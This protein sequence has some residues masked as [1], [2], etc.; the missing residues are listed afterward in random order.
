MNA[1]NLGSRKIMDDILFK[2]FY[3]KN[4]GI[5]FFTIPRYDPRMIPQVKTIPHIALIGKKKICNLI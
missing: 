5:S 3:S 4:M 2:K 1:I